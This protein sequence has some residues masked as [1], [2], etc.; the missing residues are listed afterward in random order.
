[1]YYEEK[2]G[3]LNFFV[4]VLVGSV[5]GA[6]VAL[7]VAPQSGKRTRRQL[8]KAVSTARESAG[9][10]WDDLSDDVRTAVEAGRK[11]IRV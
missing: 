11:R 4:G 2:D 6:G 3:A 10:R 7:L 1:M 9:E 5:I 8:L